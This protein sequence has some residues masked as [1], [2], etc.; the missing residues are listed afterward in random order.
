MAVAGGREAAGRLLHRGPVVQAVLVALVA[1]AVLVERFLCSRYWEQLTLKMQSSHLAVP[2][3]PVALLVQRVR[4]VLV[5]A[6]PVERR[7]KLAVEA[8]PTKWLCRLVLPK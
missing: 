5:P 4:A 2:V 1:Q 7:A 3:L 8:M 6:A